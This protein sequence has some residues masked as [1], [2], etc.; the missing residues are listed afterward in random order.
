MKV[1]GYKVEVHVCTNGE[2]WFWDP[3]GAGVNILGVHVAISIFA[4]E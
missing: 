2:M 4:K 1:K 3:N